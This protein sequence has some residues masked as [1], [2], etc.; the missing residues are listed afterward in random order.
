SEPPFGAGSV[1]T[2]S[3]RGGIE[4]GS[5]RVIHCLWKRPDRSSISTKASGR[6]NLWV[7]KIL[8]S[9]PTGRLGF[10][11]VIASILPFRPPLMPKNQMIE[12]LQVELVRLDNEIQTLT[13]KVKHLDELI[14]ANKQLE[15]ELAKKKER[16]P[17]QEE[18]VMLLKQLSDLGVRLGLDIKLWRPSSQ[19]E[20]PSKLFIRMPV[21][22]EVEGGYHTAALF[23]D[24]INKVPRIV[25]VSDLRMGSAEI[26]RSRGVIQTAFVF[27]AFVAPPE[28]KA[29]VRAAMAR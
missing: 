3:V 14:A 24:H 21:S 2:L 16:L 28:H 22:V 1:K 5:F 25:N 4:A 17:P 26:E 18:A 12:S 7:P 15:I 29:P 20:D 6:D 19:A 23:F 13:L 8:C 10:K 9:L 27:N 11:R